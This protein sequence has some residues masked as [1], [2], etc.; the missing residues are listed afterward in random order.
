MISNRRWIRIRCSLP[1][2]LLE[3]IP[4]SLSNKGKL[5]VFVSD[6]KGSLNSNLFKVQANLTY[7][8]FVSV[9]AYMH[10]KQ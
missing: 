4:Q 2:F 9:G 7:V 3:G 10:V 1:V 5:T 8:S 6:M